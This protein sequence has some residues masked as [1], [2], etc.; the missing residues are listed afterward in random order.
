MTD[1]EQVVFNP[2]DYPRTYAYSKTDR[3]VYTTIGVI[4][5][6][7]SLGLLFSV[8]LHD[9]HRLYALSTV[10]LAIFGLLCIIIPLTSQ[11]ILGPDSI[12][13]QTCFI[14]KHL[15]NR[16]DIAGWRVY[17]PKNWPRW[18]WHPS[19]VLI[20][21]DKYSSNFQTSGMEKDSFFENWYKSL[22]DYDSIRCEAMRKMPHGERIFLYAEPA[23]II[24]LFLAIYF[25]PGSYFPSIPSAGVLCLGLLPALFVYLAIKYPTHFSFYSPSSYSTTRNPAVIRKVDLGG[26]YNFLGFMLTLWFVKYAVND[27]I[28]P[29]DLWKP[30][31]TGSP[32]IIAYIAL[33]AGFFL[34]IIVRR[35]LPLTGR[36]LFAII[37]SMMILLPIT[38]I[39]I[40]SSF[41][42]MLDQSPPEIHRTVV[43]KKEIGT[44][45]SSALKDDSYIVEVESWPELRNRTGGISGKTI[46]FQVRANFYDKIEIGNSLCAYE[47]E[48]LFHLSWLKLDHCPDSRKAEKL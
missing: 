35:E 29:L 48:G 9:I 25:L 11:I 14:F 4:L 1:Q 6:T 36:R 8:P 34:P 43:A 31:L 45:F 23:I 18:F 44:D 3:R 15:L 12:E 7:A 40:T 19:P 42:I 33:V 22:P 38:A 26:S 39:G 21:K 46:P 24:F 16:D 2:D 30:W 17:G 28:F 20:T 10:L 13:S 41:N 37:L 27:G 32:V 47:Y 5:L